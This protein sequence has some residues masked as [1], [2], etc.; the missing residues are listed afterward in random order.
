MH[1][2]IVLWL[3]DIATFIVTSSLLVVE[4]LKMNIKEFVPNA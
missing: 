1:I 3:V 4:I 2:I